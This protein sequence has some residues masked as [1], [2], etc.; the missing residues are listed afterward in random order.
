MRLAFLLAAACAMLLFSAPASAAQVCSISFSTPLNTQKIY[1]M[2][3]VERS[4]CDPTGLGF[5][6]STSCDIAPNTTN[7]GGT[8]AVIGGATG[9]MTYTPPNGFSGTDT[10]AVY[11]DTDLDGTC[12]A[13]PVYITVTSSGPPTVTGISP[14]S[15][16]TSGGTSVTITGTNLASATAVK[17]GGTT[18]T[19]TANTATAI[20][21]TSPAHAAGT[22]DITVTTGSGT[23]ATSAS[24]QFTYTA[25][26]PVANA[27]SATVA[28]GSSSPITLN[29]TGGAATSVAVSTAASHGTATAS[30]TTITYTPTASYSGPDSFAYTATNGA[31]TSSPATVT[32]T[33]SSAT[34]SYSPA[35]PSAAMVGAAYS[36]SLAGASGGTSP[37]AYSL[38][39]GSLPAGLTLSSAGTLSGTARAGGNFNFT[40]TATDSS[41]GTGPFNAT[42][43]PLT[44]AVNLPAIAFSP[45]GP[46]LP[47]ATVGTSYSQSIT[48]SG[49]TSPYTYALASGS[50]P[51]GLTLSSGGTLSGTPTASGTFLFMVR[52]TDSST[53][54][55]PYTNNT[56]YV[57][58]VAAPSVS[59]S[60]AT[61]PNPAVATAYSQTV[62]ASGGTAP[63]TFSVSSGS[64]P[65]GLTLNASN[66]AIS[67]TS[68]AAG[69]YNFS[70]RATDSSTGTGAPYSGTVSYTVTVG[71]PTISVSPGTLPAGAIAT[72]YNQT[73]TASGGTGPYTFSVTAGALAAG[74]SLNPSTGVISGTPTQ[75]GPANFT[76]TA[77]DSSVAPGPYLSNRAYS[78]SISGPTQAMSPA[79]GSALS[80]NV[81]TSFSQA[82]TVSGGTAP[83]RFAALS[84]VSGTMPTGLSFNTATG[85]LSGTPTSAGTVTFHVTATD[86]STGSG[87]YSLFGAYT[88]TIGAPSVTLSPASLP[89]STVATAYSQTVSASGGT[90][91]Y[92]YTLTSG[93]LPT[94]LT[95]NTTTGAITGTP[96]AGGTFN[97]TITATDANTFTASRSYSITAAA[98]TVTVAPVTLPAAQMGTAYNQTVSASGGTAPYTFSVSAG[99]LPTG[100][101]LNAS[102]GAISGTPSAAGTYNFSIRATDNSTGTG[103]PYSGTV[104]YTVTVGVLTLGVSPATLPNPASGIA[105]NQAVSASGGT[106][107]Y[108][109]AVASGSLPA[110]LSLNPASGAITGTP[111]APGASTFT[112]RATDSSA[113]TGAPYSG[114]RSYTFTIGQVVGTSAAFS[115]TTLSNAPVTI[116]ATANASGGPF[117]AITIAAP[118]ASGTAVVNGQNIIYTPA[119]TTA[120][121]V[122]F[123]YTLTNSAGTSAP[124]TVTITVNPVPVPAAAAKQT[125]INAGQASSISITDG[126]TGG[127][128]TGATIVSVIPAGAGTATIVAGTAQAPASA[129]GVAASS[130]QGG[131]KT[132]AAAPAAS[133]SISF[134]PAATF[135][136]VAVITYT[137]SNAVATSVPAAIQISV[138]PRRDPSTDPDVTGLINAQI[139]AARRFAS[140]QLSNYNQRLEA[141]HGKGRAPSTNGLTVV[142]PGATEARCEGVIGLEARDA[143]L[144]GKTTGGNRRGLAGGKAGTDGANAKGADNGA[145]LP[146]LPGD[147]GSPT[148]AGTDQSDLAFWITGAI[149]FGFANAGTQR[150][151]FRFTTGGITAGADYHVSDQ[152]SVGAGFGYG[153]DSTDVGSAGTKSTGDSYS[154]ALYGSYR[155]LPTLFVD[156]V[157]GYGTLSFDSR[158]WVTDASEF[159]TGK[160]NGSQVFAQLSAG[161]EHRSD[162]WLISPY[163]RLSVSESKLD[164]FS[165]SGAG[166]NALTY[167]GQT[168]TAV[169]GTL[170][171][172]TEYAHA[173]PWG[174]LLPYARVEYQHD[175]N[176]QS[177]AGLAYAD[178][179]GAGPAYYVN[180]NPYGRDR[181]QVGLGTRFR[182][183]PLTFGL[184]YNVMFGMGGLQQGVRLRFV[185]PL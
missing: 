169:S 59:L 6:T 128:F 43:G 150:S 111:A 57:L 66:G 103:A 99:A 35:S 141:L 67:G 117:S 96:M 84:I 72:P 15:G 95:L 30:G 88:L 127:P 161:Y 168:V 9:E 109:Y 125:T 93:S 165:E 37:Y 73:V 121:K 5:Y 63:Y 164:P 112:V 33:V 39:S 38:A 21:A 19:V 148:T 85:T 10:G 151:G 94:G 134:V 11:T 157:A 114:T 177:N 3:E 27:V 129:G 152:F 45:A 100:L 172:R 130:M 60:P 155:P 131:D 4:T 26:P 182:T 18:A 180:G 147:N 113:G 124:I 176:G 116:Q 140:T 79:S 51:A 40:V 54:T 173:F 92:T 47:S 136:G 184:D 28:H 49:G 89:A 70:V 65:T 107:P 115:A 34:V 23:S 77:T 104:A 64:L 123:A 162:V 137:L 17:F 29:I 119:A 158:R 20:T 120:G 170:G 62:S 179:A 24:D 106:A 149:D 144:R 178:L 42:S 61:L 181:M 166:L 7:K 76:V 53:G 139:Q 145:G 90:A 46:G 12:E 55:G 183:G 32:I 171:L 154:L 132:P 22:V 48:A 68:S 110:G 74:L 13:Q 118:P 185:A 126:A 71:T 146:D 97:F 81:G 160:R 31:G 1:V 78:L 83:Y 80:G 159:A 122:T 153:R 75:S 98:P 138:T 105:Y 52:A 69:T 108:T 102:S 87:P 50:L 86:S 135:G 167:F 14:T 133:Y 174:V 41:T 8:L 143:C 36:Q 58:T 82:F 142:M 56:N 163:G 44:L 175:F 101:S 2:S 16:T 25:A 156:G 91:P